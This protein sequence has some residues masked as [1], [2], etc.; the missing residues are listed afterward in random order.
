ML[1][2]EFGNVNYPGLLIIY[3]IPFI[4][5]MSLIICYR[6]GSEVVDKDNENKQNLKKKKEWINIYWSK[7]IYWSLILLI[8]I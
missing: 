1:K 5:L 4:T 8:K 2:D 3:G 6:G 7:L